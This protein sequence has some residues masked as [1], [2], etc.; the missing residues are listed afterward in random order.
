[1]TRLTFRKR[2]LS[3]GKGVISGH[4]QAKGKA[5]YSTLHFLIS[6]RQRCLCDSLCVE[7]MERVLFLP[8]DNYD[9]CN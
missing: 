2:D 6:S 1:M 5:I 4:S 8:F 7:E 9:F 3:S